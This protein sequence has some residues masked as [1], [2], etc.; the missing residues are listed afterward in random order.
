MTTP[1]DALERSLLTPAHLDLIQR[2]DALV[3]QAVLPRVAHYDETGEAPWEDIAAIHEQGWLLAALDKQYGGL[4]YGIAGDDVLAL[5]L[6]IEHLG[7][8]SAST[9]HCFQV[10]NHTLQMVS[11]LATAEQR[12]RWLRPT[13]ERAALLVGAGAEPAGHPQTKAVRIAGGYRLRGTK[14]YATN[15]TMADWIWCPAA[16]DDVGGGSLMFMIPRDA[17]GLEIDASVWAPAGMRSCISPTLTLE[18]CF[19]PDEDILGRPGDWQN[20]HWLGQFNLGFATNY[21]GNAQG[22]YDWLIQYVRDRGAGTDPFRQAAVGELK[23]SIDAAR[24]VVYHTALLFKVDIHRALL[25]SLQAKWL[26][27]EALGKIIRLG[28]VLRYPATHPLPGQG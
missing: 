2:V 26:A 4:G 24:L 25:G 19:V 6:L 20:G 18:D 11:V 15:A 14:H 12:E 21:L 1:L 17:P 28:G 23:T 3:E 16:P 7:R 27:Q 10:H 5:Y 8:A 9:A 22:M 13:R